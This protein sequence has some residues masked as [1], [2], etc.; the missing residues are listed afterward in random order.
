[1]CGSF[2]F[3]DDFSEVPVV[4]AAFFRMSF[5]R[6]MTPAWMVMTPDAGAKP[7]A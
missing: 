1:M 7:S 5:L 4:S 3:Y 6:P 2:L